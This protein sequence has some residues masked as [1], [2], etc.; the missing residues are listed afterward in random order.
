MGFN[1]ERQ[2]EEFRKAQEDLQSRTVHRLIEMD[3]FQKHRKCFLLYNSYL[4]I[5]EEI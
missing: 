2:R 1:L 5:K 3:K 4:A